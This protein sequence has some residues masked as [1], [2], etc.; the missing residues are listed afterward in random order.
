MWARSMFGSDFHVAMGVLQGLL[1]LAQLF[2]ESL[3]TN[4]ASFGV[5]IGSKIFSAEIGPNQ[6]QRHGGWLPGATLSS[7]PA[8][9]YK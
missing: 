9:D 2:C 5:M 7:V 8:H 4:Q 1:T 6:R 3:E